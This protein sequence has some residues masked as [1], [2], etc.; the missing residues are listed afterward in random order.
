MAASVRIG[1]KGAPGKEKPSRELTLHSTV[2]SK[3]RLLKRPA[4]GKAGGVMVAT[5]SHSGLPVGIT[6]AQFIESLN[7]SPPP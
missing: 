1:L 3:S 7:V 2:N 5:M 6:C 4:A